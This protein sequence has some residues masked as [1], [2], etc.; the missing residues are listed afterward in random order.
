VRVVRSEHDPCSCTYAGQ[1]T[2]SDAVPGVS[3][4]FLYGAGRR[5]GVRALGFILE[6]SG[7]EEVVDTTW[8]VVVQKLKRPYAFFFI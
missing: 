6:R 8:S 3:P 5:R 7:S 4:G 2:G 1:G